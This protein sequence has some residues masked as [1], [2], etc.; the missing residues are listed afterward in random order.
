ML[1]LAPL[2]VL[3]VRHAE[4][5][6]VGTEGTSDAGRPLTPEGRSA[7]AE[8]ASELD[9]YGVTAIYSSPYARAVDTVTALGQ[10]RGMDVQVLDDLRE[11][12]LNLEPADDWESTLKRSWDDPDFAV[13]GGESGREAQRRAVGVLDLLR[14]RHPDGGRLVLGS[15]GN[16]IG[17]ILQALDSEVGYAFHMAMP[18]PA[19]YRIT[20]DGTRWKITGG[21]GFGPAEGELAPGLR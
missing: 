18:N 11:R 21:H 8:L 2:D 1:G 3:L 12:V 5:V 6:P 4:A 13:T 16:L 20:H 14:S 9:D 10:R 7:A 19:V 17:L 15:H